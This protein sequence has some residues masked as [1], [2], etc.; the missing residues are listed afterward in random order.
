MQLLLVLR[1]R[2][3]WVVTPTLRDRQTCLKNSE[4][5]FTK[6]ASLK[7][8]KSA[9]TSEIL[10]STSKDI[11][12]DDCSVAS[13]PLLHSTY[14]TD[15]GISGARGFNGRPSRKRTTNT[16]SFIVKD[17]ITEVVSS[18]IAKATNLVKSLKTHTFNI[19][20]QAL[21]YTRLRQEMASNECM[22][23][24]DFAENYVCKLQKEIHFVHF[25]ASKSW[26]QYTLVHVIHRPSRGDIILFHIRQ[27]EQVEV[28]SFCSISDSKNK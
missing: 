27:Q 9:D 20:H 5:V 12:Y 21:F 16:I 17:V 25:E 13:M 10:K 23:H 1:I 28:T 15:G 2:S 7:M 22:P 3:F 6:L 11:M 19:S 24:V 26:L 8:M 18:L 4:F 14:P